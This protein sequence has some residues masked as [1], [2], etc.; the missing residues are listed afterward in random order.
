MKSRCAEGVDQLEHRAV[1]RRADRHAESRVGSAVDELP[2]PGGERL[3]S[4]ALEEPH[5]GHGD[6]GQ[7]ELAHGG[8]VAGEQG[9]ELRDRGHRRVL[10][11]TSPQGV[12]EEV[13]LDVAGALAPQ[14]AVVVEA[15]HAVSGRDLRGR[16]E[17]AGDGVADR[18][19]PPGREQGWVVGHGRERN[20]RERI[21]DS[22]APGERLL[23]C[24]RDQVRRGAAVKAV[25]YDRYGPPEVLRVED[26]PD[27]LARH[28]P[29]AG[30]G[31][32]D[33]G[34]PQ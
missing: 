9:G 33:L 6:P 29:G 26:V 17:E 10:A 28:R 24:P 21:E 27:A 20:P 3:G 31:R 14:G 13:E 5:Q 30:E 19:R 1:R 23:P 18:S 8:L 7:A 32:R 34:Q 4:H 25:V 16:V 12:D 15:G 11:L 22:P 2:H